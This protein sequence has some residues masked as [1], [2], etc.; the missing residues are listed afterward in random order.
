MQQGYHA[1]SRHSSLLACSSQRKPGQPR[2]FWG[3][4]GVS[5]RLFD[6]PS[7]DSGRRAGLSIHTNPPS[8]EAKQGQCEGQMLIVPRARPATGVAS[9][10]GIKLLPCVHRVV[11]IRAEGWARHVDTSDK[12]LL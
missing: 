2:C 5:G 4:A 1:V 9:V 10:A 6:S 12:S 11:E 3:A 7:W 8:C